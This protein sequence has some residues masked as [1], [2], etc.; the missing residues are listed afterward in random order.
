MLSQHARIVLD[1]LLPSQAHPA[2]PAG[3][4]DVEFDA[5]WSD[6]ER[7]TLPSMHRP[8]RVALA[9]ATWVAPLLIGRR[10]PLAGHDRATRERALAAMGT[11]RWYLWRQLL[12]VLKMTASLCYGADPAVREAI[13]YPTQPDDPGG[14][15]A[16]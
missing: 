4:M 8:F 12:M 15:A 2:L 6:F 5:F 13:G 10:P 14:K 9:A 16:G 3:L 1:T 11:S 7:T